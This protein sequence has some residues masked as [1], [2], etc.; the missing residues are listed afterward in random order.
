[1]EYYLAIKKIQIKVKTINRFSQASGEKQ[2]AQKN[3]EES[4]TYTKL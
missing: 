3:I 2:L 4:R 1:M